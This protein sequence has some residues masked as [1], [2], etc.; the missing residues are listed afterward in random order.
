MKRRLLEKMLLVGVVLSICI[1][2]AHA[3]CDEEIDVPGTELTSPHY[4]NTYP[5]GLDCTQVIFG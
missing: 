3:S 4:P 1:K 5:G 2:L